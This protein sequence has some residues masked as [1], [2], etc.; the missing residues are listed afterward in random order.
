MLGEIHI[1]RKD[2][3]AAEATLQKALTYD[4]NHVD[5]YRMLAALYND[6]KKFDEAAK[7]GAKAPKKTTD[8]PAAKP[9]AKKP[10]AKKPAPAKKAPAKK[11]ADTPAEA[12]EA[13]E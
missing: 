2:Y 7:A 6:M 12:T 4:E 11:K 9:A 10:A 1:K 3:P 13:G 5:T 8:A